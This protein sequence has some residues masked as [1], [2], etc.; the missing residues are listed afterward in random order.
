MSAGSREPHLFLIDGGITL[1]EI[2]EDRGMLDRAPAAVVGRAESA[3][4][5]TFDAHGLRVAVTRSKDSG[6]WSIRITG[7][8]LP[9]PYA[10]SIVATYDPRN[11]FRHAKIRAAELANPEDPKGW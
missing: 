8:D 4:V 10:E 3:G 11:V 7:G 5:Y 9:R 6:R 1:Q 2:A